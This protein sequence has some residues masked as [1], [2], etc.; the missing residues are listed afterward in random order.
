MTPRHPPRSSFRHQVSLALAP[1]CRPYPQTA[2]GCPR[3]PPPHHRIAGC[4]GDGRNNGAARFL[5]AHSA[6]WT[7]PT[8]GRP[9][10]ATEV[11]C[12]SNSPCVRWSGRSSS[13]PG[14]RGAPL[15]RNWTA[16]RDF[17]LFGLGVIRRFCGQRFRLGQ[18]KPPAGAGIASE[19]AF[20][21]VADATHARVIGNTLRM[22]NWRKFSATIAWLR[23]STL[24]TPGQGLAAANQHPDEVVIRAGHSV[25]ASTTSTSASVLPG[26]PAPWA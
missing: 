20:E 1:K 26:Q 7:C 11:S 22:P 4:A 12:C 3:T 6:V 24:F 10:M 8:F 16:L 21:Q 19:I 25:R 13:S 14:S 17:G 9:M 23:P 15:W 5:S 18:R 2:V